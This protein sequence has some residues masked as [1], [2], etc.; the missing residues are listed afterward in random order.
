MG[1]IWARECVEV[2]LIREQIQLLVSKGEEK[3]QTDQYL[4]DKVRAFEQKI[5]EL[6]LD[7]RNKD[8][9]VLALQNDIKT[10]GDWRE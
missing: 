10:V 9:K 6:I 4:L 2:G 8:L 1:V 7:V 5:E 3:D